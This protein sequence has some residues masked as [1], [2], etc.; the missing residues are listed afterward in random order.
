M[1]AES[2][3]FS[4]FYLEA[5]SG[6]DSPVGQN[7]IRSAREACKLTLVVG[8]GIRDGVAARKA[9]DAGA[10]WIITGNLAEEYCPYLSQR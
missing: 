2:Y 6:A 7:L 4:M 5:G 9:A 8:G 10:D 1:A 3:G